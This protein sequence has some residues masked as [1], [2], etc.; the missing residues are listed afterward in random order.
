MSFF[1][2][3]KDM[4]TCKRPEKNKLVCEIYLILFINKNRIKVQIKIVKNL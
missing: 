4:F 1:T 2:F 3:F